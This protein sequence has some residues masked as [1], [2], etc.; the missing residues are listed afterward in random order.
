MKQTQI[1]DEVVIAAPVDRVWAAI[2]D[3][4]AHG[5]WH[6]FAT[7]IRGAHRMGAVR[8]CDVRMGRTNGHTVETCT[9]YRE[10]AEIRWRIDSDSTGFAR[11]VSA[12]DAGFLLQPDGSQRTQVVAE[13]RFTPARLMARLMAP[14][15]RSKFHGAQTRIL[16]ALKSHVERAA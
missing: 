4:E 11:M 12:W 2:A 6:P 16:A 5:R 1:R 9:V 14:L 15:I 10:P 7:A 3:I 8:E 13:S